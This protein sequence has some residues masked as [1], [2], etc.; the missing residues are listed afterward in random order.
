[1]KRFLLTLLFL[2]LSSFAADSPAGS[3]QGVAGL[4]L[5][6]LR[7][8]FKTDVPGTLD[9]VKA[10]GVTEVEVAQT[11]GLGGEKLNEMLLARGLKPISE[12]FQYDALTMDIDAVIQEAK[13]LNLKYIACPWIP[14]KEA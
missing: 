12:H 6:S 10:Y 4:Q 2:P 7:D 9:K 5:Y 3:F 13:A 8:L 1:M 14:H 11:Y